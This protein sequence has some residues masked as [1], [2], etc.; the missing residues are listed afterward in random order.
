[1]IFVFV[2]YFILAAMD[3]KLQVVIIIVVT[4]MERLRYFYAT[5]TLLVRIN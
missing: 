2:N 3:N 5:G 4:R 1:M